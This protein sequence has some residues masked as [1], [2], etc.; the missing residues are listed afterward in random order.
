MVPDTFGIDDGDRSPRA[1]PEAID[2]AAV[3]QWFGIGEFEGFQA[4]LEKLPRSDG[5]FANGALRLGLVRTEENVTAILIQSEFAGCN[6]KRVIHDDDG[7]Y[8]RRGR[9]ASESRVSGPRL[10]EAQG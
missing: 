5:F 6:P 8:V 7:G 2:F 9:L 1:D 4:V 10:S 3:N